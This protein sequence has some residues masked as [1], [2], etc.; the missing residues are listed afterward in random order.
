MKRLL[1]CCSFLS[2]TFV[3]SL[4]GNQAGTECDSLKTCIAGKGWCVFYQFPAKGQKEIAASEAYGDM[5]DRFTTL[6]Q[7]NP[8]VNFFTIQYDLSNLLDGLK[9]TTKDR[10]VFVGKG[11]EAL[12]M[13]GLFVD[14]PS[15]LE[16][17]FKSTEPTKV[18][19]LTGSKNDV[20]KVLTGKKCK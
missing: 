11:G 14:D 10:T 15:A 2:L 19:P 12:E 13:Q 18:S 8:N 4:A 20:H 7:R 17:F 9:K 1:V 3:P 5:V 6:Q 16:T